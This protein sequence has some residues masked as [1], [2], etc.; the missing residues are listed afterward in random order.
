MAST[1]S[2]SSVQEADIATAR[3]DI[4][5]GLTSHN[6][7]RTVGAVA[8]AVRDGLARHFASSAVR[9]VLADAQSTDGTREAAREVVGASALLEVEIEPRA[10]FG[11][12]PYHGQPGRSAALRAILQAA[13]RLGV[14]ACAVMDAGLHSADPEW[15]E[16]LLAPVMADEF[17]YVSPYYV[18]HVNEGAITKS[19]V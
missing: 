4:V 2:N 16:R 1:G 5:V 6:D 14:K 10:E 9:F 11:K 19:I 12:L 3:A 7:V 17:D 18:R 15:I 13:Q 8:R